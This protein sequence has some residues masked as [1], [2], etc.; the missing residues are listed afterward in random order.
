VPC[1]ANKRLQAEAIAAALATLQHADAKNASSE[2]ATSSSSALA[3]ALARA[4]KAQTQGARHLRELLQQNL[5]LIQFFS[6]A[7]PF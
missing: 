4:E 7:Q 3:K 6:N 5:C 2:G 1:L